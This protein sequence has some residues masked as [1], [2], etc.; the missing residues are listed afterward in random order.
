MGVKT[1]SN[2]YRSTFVDPYPN[3][4]KNR[5]VSEDTPIDAEA[6]QAHTDALKEI[7]NF[8]NGC[9]KDKTGQIEREVLTQAEYDE[10]PDTKY[11]DGKIYFITDGGPGV[12]YTNFES[13][14]F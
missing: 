5:D 3:G 14:E 1:M 9:N 13:E 12:H 8:L 10:L 7:D 6:M 2:T 11:S 4:W